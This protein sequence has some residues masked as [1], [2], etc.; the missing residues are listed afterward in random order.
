MAN[1]QQATQSMEEQVQRGLSGE[2]DVSESAMGE[3]EPWDLWETKLCL[4]SLLIGIG[5]LIVLG[6]LINAFLL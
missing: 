1:G 5:A 2:L 6:A 4:W 3:W